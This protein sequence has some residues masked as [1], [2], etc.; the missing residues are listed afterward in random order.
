MRFRRGHGEH[1]RPAIGLE[2]GIERC[3]IR[4]A[5][6]SV[7]RLERGER[8]EDDVVGAYADHRPV[9]GMELVDLARCMPDEVVVR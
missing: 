7:D 6:D 4:P 1:R 5:A 8:V 2:D 9:G 3:P